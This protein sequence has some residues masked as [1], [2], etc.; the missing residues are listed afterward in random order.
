MSSL[1]PAGSVSTEIDAT[2]AQMLGPIEALLPP[3]DYRSASGVEIA[4]MLRARAPR[5]ELP[6]DPR[7]SVEDAVMPGP[8]GTIQLRF[9]RPAGSNGATVI[10]FHG[11]GWVLG[12]IASDEARC[13]QLARMTGCIVVSVEYRLAPEHPFPAPLE[14]CYA[15]TRW[16]AD[17]AAALGIDPG[18]IAVMGASAGG[19]LAAAVAMLARERGGPVIAYQLLVY[20][21]CDVAMD[22]ESHARHGHRFPLTREDMAWFW[23]Q[24]AP[25]E[26]AAHGHASILRA[27]DLR[28][29][30][31]AHIV[32]AGCDILRDEGIAYA[33]RLTQAG[34][35][36][37]VS[38]YPGMVHGFLAVAFNH[39]VSQAAMRDKAEGLR[40]VFSC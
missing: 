7:V 3:T 15:A 9:Y 24:Y 20:P 12:S 38:D 35:E 16:V 36:A 18:R 22:T 19:N 8:E 1:P 13:L 31:P 11:G 39:P 29:L 33:A 2:L 30:P 10:N 32:T 34:V 4:R 28:G 17:N 21:V 23:Q 25:G 26:H 40:N 37:R 27:Q 14:D 6:P 5:N